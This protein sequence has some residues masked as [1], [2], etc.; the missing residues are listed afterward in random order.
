M[1][2]LMMPTTRLAAAPSVTPESIEI[3]PNDDTVSVV[4][5]STVQIIY[6]LT[7]NG[8]YTGTVT[9]SVTGLPTGVTGDWS[10]SSLSGG[11]T[12]TTLTLT[13]ADDATPVSNDVFTVTFSGSGVDDAVDNGTV[14]VTASGSTPDWDFLRDF[15]SGSN[16][17][18]AQA[19]DG[20]DGSAAIKSNEQAY[21]GTLSAKTTIAIGSDGDGTTGGGIDFPTTLVKGDTLWCDIRFFFPTGFE[22]ATPGNG[23][24][25][26]LRFRLKTPAEGH[27]G[28]NDIQFMDDAGQS[29]AFRMIQ[30][31][32]G[33]W[34][35]FGTANSVTRNTWHRMSVCLKYDNVLQSSG[36]TARS[37]VWFNG[38]LVVDDATIRTLENA[39]DIVF[40]AFIYTFWNGGS[41]KTQSHYTDD[42]RFAKNGTPSWALDLEGVS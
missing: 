19:A 34:V 30:E 22:I 12:T 27:V 2:L 39:T 16:G 42:I 36:G 13:A 3:S 26:F 40:L 35:N 32:Q 28:Y 6:T 24:L 8:G 11:D 9:P 21:S 38:A 15:N 41:P 14:T 31:V 25:K 17:S 5:D 18:S 23:S 4:Q 20:F 33:S 1:S 37:R 29:S 7:R 10:D